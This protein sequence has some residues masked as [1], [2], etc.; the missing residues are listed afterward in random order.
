M[1]G[2]NDEYRLTW[3]PPDAIKGAE[4]VS[5]D[6]RA[7][8]AASA[9]GIWVLQPLIEP[10]GANPINCWWLDGGADTPASGLA[11]STTRHLGFP[12]RLIWRHSAR[13]ESSL[14]GESSEGPAYRVTRAVA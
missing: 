14:T 11:E 8:S 5:N 1:T 6:P 10:L 12:V 2:N 4:L 13:W 7:L 9:A 3:I